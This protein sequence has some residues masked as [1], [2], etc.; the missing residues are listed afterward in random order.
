MCLK[1]RRLPDRL[2]WPAPLLALALVT[3]SAGAPSAWAAPTPP[4]SSAPASTPADD[5]AAEAARARARAKTLY[6]K[7][8]EETERAKAD[9]L[10]K[11]D[12]DA[13]KRFSK[14]LKQFDEATRLDPDYFEA[15][16]MVGYCARKTGDLKRAFA[17]YEKSLAINPDY[18]EAHE[19]LGEAWLLSGDI[20]KAREQLDWLKE[21]QSEEAA[22][23]EASIEAAE[24]AKAAA[25]T[26]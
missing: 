14:A 19:Y 1:V 21:K 6:G 15:W 13:T 3:A 17:A 7:A 10:A 11:K 8:Y 26:P 16:N 4:K 18:E 23:L 20:A 22:E 5:S 12:K 2:M 24:K 25:G 9:L